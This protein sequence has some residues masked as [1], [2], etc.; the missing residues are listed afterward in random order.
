MHSNPGGTPILLINMLSAVL[1][2]VEDAAYAEDVIVDDVQWA[3][4]HWNVSEASKSTTDATQAD[5]DVFAYESEEDPSLRQL[6]DWTGIDRD[7]RSAFLIVGTLRPEGML[8]M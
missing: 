4:I 7:R 3:E 1:P 6:G 5:D 8:S 2:A